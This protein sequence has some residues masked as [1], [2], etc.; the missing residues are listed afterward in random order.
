MVAS[1]ALI[2]QGA[3]TAQS[4]EADRLRAERKGKPVENV[5]G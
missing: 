4:P 2:A 5:A 3:G 1:G